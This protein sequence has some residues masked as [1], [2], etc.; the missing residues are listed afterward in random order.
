MALDWIP[1]YPSLLP[2]KPKASGSASTTYLSTGGSGSETVGSSTFD[3]SSLTQFI[4]SFDYYATSDRLMKWSTETNLWQSGT[5]FFTVTT[6]AGQRDG[7]SG[8]RLSIPNSNLVAN[9]GTLRQT[10]APGT[11]ITGGFW[12][13]YSVA[14]GRGIAGVYSNG[15]LQC[16]LVLN[17]NHTLSIVRSTNSGN[18]LGTSPS[19]LT[20]NKFYFIEWSI[21]IDSSAGQAD[22]WVNGVPY[23]TINNANTREDETWANQFSIGLVRTDGAVASAVWDYD[24]VY[25]TTGDRR[26]D[27]QPWGIGRAVAR[28]AQAG[29]GTFTDLT[30]SSGTDHGDMVDD[31]LEDGDATV[32]TGTLVGATDTYLLN[33]I[34]DATS[35]KAVQTVVVGRTSG[36]TINRW[37]SNVFVINGVVYEGARVSCGTT[38]THLL[39]Q[40]PLS[41]DT[42]FPFTIDE[43]NAAEGGV[44]VVG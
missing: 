20:P 43:L 24:D 31:L 38:Y 42:G 39:T 7:S 22:V 14:I 28:I 16:Q 1:T 30:P 12:F 3:S 41:P 33:P 40:Y 34:T 4:D 36:G 27:V 18:V 5:S 9:E 35:V 11:Y 17:A 26:M 6:S 25:V 44:K 29:N 21:F 10:L 19:Q 15:T 8:M 32:N 2:A 37:A 23:L 13:R